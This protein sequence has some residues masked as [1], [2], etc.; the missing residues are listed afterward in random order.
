M[1][2][3]YL[4]CGQRLSKFCICDR[5]RSFNSRNYL[6][7]RVYLQSTSPATDELTRALILF[8]I[9]IM[10]YLSKA[11]SYFNKNSASR[12]SCFSVGLSADQLMG[13]GNEVAQWVV[14]RSGCWRR[15]RKLGLERCLWGELGCALRS[16]LSEYISGEKEELR[17]EELFWDLLDLR[18]RSNYH[19]YLVADWVKMQLHE[20]LW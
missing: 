13:C 9:A 15:L 7:L 8:Y 20:Q 10:I 17:F 5:E 3:T 12:Y 1:S 14:G 11:K 16:P 19:C 6:S 18:A 4:D 2:K